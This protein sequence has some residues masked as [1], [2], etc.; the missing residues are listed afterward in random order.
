MDA[1]GDLDIIAGNLG[2]NSQLTA[3]ETEPLQLYAADVDQNGSIDPLLFYHVQ[4]T[5]WPFASRDDLIGQLPHLKKKFLFFKDYANAQL[6]D[7]LPQKIIDTALVCSAQTL[8]SV[9]YE[10]DNGQLRAHLLPYRAQLAPVRSIAAKDLNGDGYTDLILG[11]N[12]LQAK[13]KLGRLDGNHGVVLLGNGDEGFLALSNG[14]SGLDFRGS[15]NELQW[16]ETN[17]GDYLLAAT[18]NGA[19]Q[20]YRLNEEYR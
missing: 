13:V 15:I 12:L 6:P 20:T 14:L 4:G 17:N 1:D 18:N 11:G 19:L 9:Y 7:I 8:A 2:L 10:N 16:I 5:S 3:S